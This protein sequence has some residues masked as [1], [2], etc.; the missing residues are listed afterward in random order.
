MTR[1]QEENLIKR[2]AKEITNEYPELKTKYIYDDID[3]GWHIYYNIDIEGS[4]FLDFIDEKINEI[5]EKG[6]GISIVDMPSEFR[7]ELV[8]A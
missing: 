7:K 4:G 1:K 2:V 5:E 3:S 8:E 6:I